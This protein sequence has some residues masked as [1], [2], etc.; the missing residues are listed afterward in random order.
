MCFP[1]G[2]LR[3]RAERSDIW[4]QGDPLSYTALTSVR[5]RS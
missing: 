3:Q 1:F 5:E 4:E 2:F